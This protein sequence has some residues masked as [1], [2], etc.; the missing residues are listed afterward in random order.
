LFTAI[1]L[2]VI[3]AAFVIAI[4]ACIPGEVT[5]RA[6]LYFDDLGAHLNEHSGAGG[7]REGAREIENFKAG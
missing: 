3:Q 5:A 4:F 2:H 7:A 6:G 1:L